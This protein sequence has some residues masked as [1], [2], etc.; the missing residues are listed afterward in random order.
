[1]VCAEDYRCQQKLSDSSSACDGQVR[2]CGDF[3]DATC[4]SPCPTS[5]SIDEHCDPGLFCADGVC[6]DTPC[7]GLCESCEDG[8]CQADPL[9]MPDAG[10]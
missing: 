7:T 8:I 2:S 1:M 9:C 10:L 6:C 4:P 5:C 3:A